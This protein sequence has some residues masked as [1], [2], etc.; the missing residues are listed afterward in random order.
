MKPSKFEALDQDIRSDWLAHPTT[1]AFID[2]MDDLLRSKSSEIVNTCVHQAEPTSGA[3]T[4][5]GGEIGMLQT[6]K[7]IIGKAT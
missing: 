6:L 3:L 7:Q 4:R 5:L 1:S 2:L